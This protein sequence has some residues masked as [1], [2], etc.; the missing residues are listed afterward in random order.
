MV[1]ERE[2]VLDMLLEILEKKEYSHLVIR[3][4]LDKYNYLDTKSKAF[5][6]RVTEGT[7]ERLITVDYILDCFSKTPVKKMKPLIRN[8]LRMSVYQMVYMDY[9]PDSAICNEAVKLAGKRGFRT[10]QGYVNGVLRNISRNKDQLVYPKREQDVLRYYSVQYSMPEWL[11]KHFMTAYGEKQ[12]EQILEDIQQIHPVTVRYC[13]NEEF[14][15]TWLAKLKEQQVLIQQH[16]YYE[17]AFILEGTEN[18][19]ELPGYQNGEFTVQDVSSML[20]TQA[21]GLQG[22]EFVLDVCAA[23][24]G[25]SLHAAGTLPKGHVLARDLTEYKVAQI[26]ENRDRLQL[27]NLETQ[28]YDACVLNHTMIEKADVVY[29]DLPCSGLGIMGK[30]R[31]IRYRISPEQM[32]ELVELQKKILSVV[33]HYVKPGGLLIYST[34]TINKAENEHMVKWIE[35]QLPFKRESL[36]PYLPEELQEEGK[37]GMLQLLPGIHKSDGFFLAKLRKKSRDLL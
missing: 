24:G 12:T 9:I 22:E 5:I 34:C 2:I 36:A 33:W 4:V 10:L 37:E 27:T 31:D 23:P 17:N 32:K 8:L 21:A 20:V 29:A 18:I 28:V 19:R 30:K 26:N 11:V 16:P 6:K 1:N 25:K 14:R 7:V 3:N 15:K 13:K 35:E